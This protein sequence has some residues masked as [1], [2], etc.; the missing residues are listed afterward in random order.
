MPTPEIHSHI[1]E[2][3]D[4]LK[5]IR[6]EKNLTQAEIAGVLEQSQSF[7]S[8]YES[9]ERILDI[10]EVR[11]ICERLGLS[12]ADFCSRLETKIGKKKDRAREAQ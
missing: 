9:G 2:L 12:L 7:V 5:E 10:L 3:Q 4:L 1:E 11:F 8:K 6:R